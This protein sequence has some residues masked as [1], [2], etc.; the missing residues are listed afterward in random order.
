MT[1]KLVFSALIL[2]LAT[3]AYAADPAPAATTTAAK[4]VK[5]DSA[6]SRPDCI[7]STGSLILPKNGGCLN[8][9]GRAY[10]RE[11]IERTGAITTSGA[12]QM[13][14]PSITIRH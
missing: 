5:A 1:R 4:S 2:G 14:D 9:P 6:I 3:A 7:R 11:D 10:T 12:L 8:V 13:L